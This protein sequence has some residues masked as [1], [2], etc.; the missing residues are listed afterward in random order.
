M[1]NNLAVYHL[2]NPIVL[3]AFLITF[4]FIAYKIYKVL[5][6]INNIIHKNK[7]PNKIYIQTEE[8]KQAIDNFKKIHA[9]ARDNKAKLQ[10]EI[11]KNPK[12]S[13]EALRKM[14][15]R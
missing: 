3:F 11:S 8:K 4:C 1:L 2:D 9:K 12:E 7:Q 6:L 14:M 5:K 10:K 15:K 13:A